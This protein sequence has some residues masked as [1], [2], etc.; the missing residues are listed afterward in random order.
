MLDLL[1]GHIFRIVW[2][3]RHAVVTHASG[4][5]LAHLVIHIPLDLAIFLVQQVIQWGLLHHVPRVLDCG[6]R[7]CLGADRNGLLLGNW[8]TV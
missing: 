8:S 1:F 2:F 4:A 6:G 7:G 5:M 3:E